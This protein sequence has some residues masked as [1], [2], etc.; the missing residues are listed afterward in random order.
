MMIPLK[1]VL[2]PFLVLLGTVAFL[3]HRFYL[4]FAGFLSAVVASIVLFAVIII[5]LLGLFDR[6]SVVKTQR[7]PY[8]YYYR[9]MQGPYHLIVQDFMRLFTPEQNSL[10]A[11]DPGVEYMGLY[12]DDP[13]TLKLPG[14]C[15]GTIGFAFSSQASPESVS[16]VKMVK[17][18]KIVLPRWG[19]VE[20]SMR[21]RTNL[22]YAVAA[23]RLP[24]RVFE[25]VKDLLL[26]EKRLA[27]PVYEIGAR[28]ITAYGFAVEGAD[29]IDGLVPSGHQRRGKNKAD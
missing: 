19:A 18:P 26:H 16:A 29:A 24:S 25:H 12:W 21:V 22:A 2:I 27:S 7:G 23:M 9:Q 1:Q 15:R 3:Y 8:T 10:L 17:L 20:A 6:I 14:T 28:G 11:E 4:S 13:R 5:Y